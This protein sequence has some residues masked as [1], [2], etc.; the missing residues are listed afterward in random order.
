MSP[1]PDS[2]DKRVSPRQLLK[3]RVDARALSE[4]ERLG[5][6]AG[7]GFPELDAE[8]LAL[9]RPRQGLQ[10]TESCDVSVSGLRLKLAGLAVEAGAALSMDIH[11]PGDRRVI[12]LLGDV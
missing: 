2:P 7:Q 3:L 5:I 8:G 12:R 11:L 1:T 6:L 4:Q 9:S 10:R